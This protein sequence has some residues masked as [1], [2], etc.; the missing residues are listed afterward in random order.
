MLKEFLPIIIVLIIF[1]IIS[2]L[3]PRDTN[4]YLPYIYTP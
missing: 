4:Y 1:I 2:M 3:V